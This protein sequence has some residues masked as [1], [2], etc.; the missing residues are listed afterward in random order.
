MSEDGPT[1]PTTP[2]K[3]KAATPFHRPPPLSLDELSNN[4]LITMIEPSKGD[5]DSAETLLSSAINTP[6]SRATS[7]GDRTTNELMSRTQMRVGSADQWQ[8]PKSSLRSPPLSEPRPHKKDSLTYSRTSHAAFGLGGSQRR[9]I[10]D[11]SFNKVS[12]ELDHG[13]ESPSDSDNSEAEI[14]NS[15]SRPLRPSVRRQEK[16]H[17]FDTSRTFL[18]KQPISATS[19]LPQRSIGDSWGA[20]AYQPSEARYQDSIEHLSLEP[21]DFQESLQIAEKDLTTEQRALF[22]KFPTP[23]SS[24]S[25]S[26]TKHSDV[27]LN[28]FPEH[29]NFTT[30]PIFPKITN[31]FELPPNTTFQ[32]E[33]RVDQ[34]MLEREFW[35]G[36]IT[37]PI[38]SDITNSFE[39]PPN[40]APQE[41]KKVDQ[42]QREEEFFST[43]ATSPVSSGPSGLF[44]PPSGKSIRSPRPYASSLQSKMR[45]ASSLDPLISTNSQTRPNPTDWPSVPDN[46]SLTTQR[47]LTSP[48]SVDEP[49]ESLLHTTS[50]DDAKPKRRGRPF[51]T[52]IRNGNFALWGDL[53]TYNGTNV[54][55]WLQAICADYA[56]KHPSH[57]Y[58]TDVFLEEIVLYCVIT[59]TIRELQAANPNLNPKQVAAEIRTQHKKV[60]IDA[61]GV[62]YED[63]FNA[64][65]NII[66]KYE[67]KLSTTPNDPRTQE[68]TQQLAFLKHLKKRTALLML[69]QKKVASEAKYELL[70]DSLKS[71]HFTE[72]EK[73]K[74]IHALLAGDLRVTDILKRGIKHRLW[75][76]LAFKWGNVFRSKRLSKEEVL[77]IAGYSWQNQ[78]LERTEEQKKNRL[79]KGVPLA[80]GKTITSMALCAFFVFGT[81]AALGLMFGF[82]APL[83]AVIAVA[84]FVSIC[85]GVVCVFSRGQAMLDSAAFSP[86]KQK[87]YE[88]AAK[89]SQEKPHSRWARKAFF[90][91]FTLIACIA[92]GAT[93]W[94]GMTGLLVAIGAAVVLSN[95]FGLAF[96][97]LLSL[98]AAIS[99]Y[100]FQATGI[101][102]NYLKF[103]DLI[104]SRFKESFWKGSAMLL[105]SFIVLTVY[106]VL[107]WFTAVSGIDKIFKAVDFK[108]DSFALALSLTSLITTMFVNTFSQ[109]FKVFS[110]QTH[111][112]LKKHH[113][114]IGKAWLQGTRWEKAKVFLKCIMLV[115]NE[116]AYSIAGGFVS[117]H[118]AGKKW[119]N[120]AGSIILMILSP[121]VL[122]IISVAF[123]WSAVLKS[124]SAPAQ[125][126]VPSPD[127]TTI[128]PTT[129]SEPNDLSLS[130][131]ARPDPISIPETKSDAQSP[132]TTTIADR[133]EAQS[134]ASAWP[135]SSP[136]S[137]SFIANNPS[138]TFSSR[139]NDRKETKAF[140]PTTQ[141]YKPPPVVLSSP[142][143]TPHR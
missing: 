30:S 104:V 17:S 46:D 35:G 51:F 76:F 63:L 73:D 96:V 139:D 83:G 135:K 64:L 3:D 18:P 56:G 22:E 45:T 60:P 2:N 91:F 109:V 136:D 79:W 36:F 133:V 74:V 72:E 66:R 140:S 130:A 119:G 9:L 131:S 108:Q 101:E 92:A 33:K 90:G 89:N 44:A 103:K 113:A 95:P 124:K 58:P 40:T 14:T 67:E 85:N 115:G 26:E 80:A 71:Y 122:L 25:P 38:P 93:A 21:F 28:L 107:T 41:R 125:E 10:Q 68:R 47:N 53:A 16:K 34:A 57:S 87:T 19:P 8:E 65:R 5:L 141:G 121:V 143:A 59:S 23:S 75:S 77:Q 4:S 15:P 88:T 70:I 86:E 24:T 11:K 82:S 61:S 134:P 37:S 69:L 78:P 31:L 102:E 84:A 54:R 114:A 132:P 116:L 13:H 100:S 1:P 12:E 138:I 110:P 81:F 43:F 50:P 117:G 20:A 49:S 129:T 52:N 39:S 48:Q 99:F 137:P 32:E 123:T 42:A 55:P 120:P 94:T 62:S 98:I 27:E 7:V 118:D 105:V 29:R 97:A 111:E 128:A 142:P 127:N 112:E 106:G 126:N 6:D